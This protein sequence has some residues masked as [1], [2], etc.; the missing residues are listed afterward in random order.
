[1]VAIII[2]FGKKNYFSSFLQGAKAGFKGSI[3]LLPSMCALIVSVSM[4]ISS[5]AERVFASFLAPAFDKIGVPSELFPLIL[6]RPFSG[7]A[8]IATYEEIISLYGADS[9]IGICASVIMASSDT[10]IYVICMYF[11][12]TKIR[13]TRHAF[14]VALFISFFCV[15]LSC[16]VSRLFLNM[17]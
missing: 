14:P 17:I 2:M 5:G 10:V 12:A 4:F 8:S 1:M 16:I 7:S 13:K 11:S 3:A 9:F 6:L 15:L